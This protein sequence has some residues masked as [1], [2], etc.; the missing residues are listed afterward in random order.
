MSGNSKIRNTSLKIEN[1]ATSIPNC[2]PFI[3][4]EIFS[5]VSIFSAMSTVTENYK[6]SVKFL[7]KRDALVTNETQ[8]SNSYGYDHNWKMLQYN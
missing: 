1:S 3:K 8:L 2:H 4:A 5:C 6:E 7:G